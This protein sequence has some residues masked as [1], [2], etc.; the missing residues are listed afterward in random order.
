M[1]AAEAKAYAEEATK[2]GKKYGAGTHA[3][4]QDM[5]GANPYSFFNQGGQYNAWNRAA[6]AAAQL[7]NLIEEEEGAQKANEQ[8]ANDFVRILQEAVKVGGDG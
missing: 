2:L 3:W 1:S 5:A 4:A 7:Y 6:E 8:M